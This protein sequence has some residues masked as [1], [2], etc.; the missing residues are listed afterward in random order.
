MTVDT[1]H[2]VALI[3]MRS[4]EALSTSERIRLLNALGEIL[5]EPESQ[6]AKQAAW[7]ISRAETHQLKFLDLIEKGDGK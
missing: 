3:A 2:F 6:E 7:F 1:I 5:P 4:Y